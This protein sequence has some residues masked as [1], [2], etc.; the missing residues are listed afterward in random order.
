MTRARWLE[1][2][3]RLIFAGA[4]HDVSRLVI[5]R[6]DRLNFQRVTIRPSLGGEPHDLLQV[7]GRLL[8]ADPLKPEDLQGEEVTIGERDLSLRWEGEVRT[9]VSEPQGEHRFGL[10]RCAYYEG[11][12]GCV[13]VR[14]EEGDEGYAI[15]GTPLDPARLDLRFT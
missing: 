8:A 12:D 14:V 11:D 6:A 15:L 4:D 2:G 13:A 9:E 10:G 7:E 1:P 3:D 5:G